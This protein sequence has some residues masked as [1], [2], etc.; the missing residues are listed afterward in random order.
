M[1]KSDIERIITRYI[2]CKATQEELSILHKWVKKDNNQQVFKK[3]VQTHFLIN[4]H[5]R[6]W[7][8]EEAFKKFLKNI[9]ENNTQKTKPF[10]NS[11]WKYAVAITLIAFTL[12]FARLYN[13]VQQNRDI[14]LN[15]NLITLRLDNGEVLNLDPNTNLN[16]KSKKEEITVSLIDGMLTQKNGVNK[17]SKQKNNELNIPYGKKLSVILQDGTVV[18]LNSGSTLS[19]P[20]SFL[21]NDKRE[22]YLQGEAF[23]KVSKNCVKPFIVNTD[24]IYIRV[25]STMF[26]VSAYAEDPTTEVVLAEGSVRLAELG[27]DIHKASL[28]LKPSQKASKTLGVKSD[29]VIEDVDITPY[30]SWTKGLLTFEN[31]TMFEI[32]KKLKRRYNIH[33]INQFEKLSEKRF[34]GK[35]D[36]E[37]INCVLKTIQTHTPFNYQR[38]GNTIILKEPN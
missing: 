38:E 21:A 18:M 9:K 8:T 10:R 36:K 30:L 24:K 12:M 19:Y 34:T 29:F 5:N 11:I 32:I 14:Q 2:N 4:Y 15:S 33:I 3:H 27:A 23:F 22:V 17:E 20:S 31:E 1:T 6:N 7:K 26:N 35:F 16:I 25:Y 28:K 37:D 13:T